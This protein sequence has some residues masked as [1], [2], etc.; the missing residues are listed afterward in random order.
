M[1]PRPDRYDDAY[2]ERREKRLQDMFVLRQ[3]SAVSAFLAVA[4]TAASVVEIPQG[5]LTELVIV[6]M[7]VG[8]W[9]VAILTYV[10]QRAQSAAEITI[11]REYEQWSAHES[12]KPKRKINFYLADDGELEDDAQSTELDNQPAAIQLPRS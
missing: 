8:L 7:M 9:L 2:M 4:L 1:S 5:G 12:E 10:I 11:Q 3:V 6:S